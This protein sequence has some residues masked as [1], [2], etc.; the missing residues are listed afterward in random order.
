MLINK[1]EMGKF[2]YTTF[3][4]LVKTKE[5]YSEIEGLFTEYDYGINPK[6]IILS[7]MIYEFHSEMF[8]KSDE[9]LELLIVYKSEKLIDLFERFRVDKSIFH[10]LLHM[11]NDF[12]EKF[13]EWKKIDAVK[14]VS[15]MNN[16]YKELNIYKTMKFTDNIKNEIETKQEFIKKRV[17]LLKHNYNVF[18][19]E[20]PE[21]ELE[22]VAERAFW[23]LFK[24]SL[25]RFESNTLNEKDITWITSLLD[26]IK[27][28]LNSLT[29]NNLSVIDET[30]KILDIKFIEQRIIHN[31]M[32][33]EFLNELLYFIMNRIKLLQAA[34]DDKDTNRWI[35][36]TTCLLEYNCHYYDLLPVFFKIVYTKINR[37]QE[38]FETYISQTN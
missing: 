16:S 25:V 5:L 28:L 6:M 1:D 37:I 8:Y 10:Q 19:I 31:S 23:D 18:E 4:E 13:D 22:D 21:I 30:N 20:E 7:Y 3:T 12:V 34:V 35:Y 26:E 33:S 32:D 2:T 17:D 14:M 36:L 9:L 27:G 29:P 11:Y 38:Q 24:E 15:F